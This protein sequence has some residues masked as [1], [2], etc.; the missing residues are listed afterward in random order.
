MKCRPDLEHRHGLDGVGIGQAVFGAERVQGLEEV[1]GLR[2]WTC[3]AT[4]TGVMKD[5]DQVPH[6]D[7]ID[8]FPVSTIGTL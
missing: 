2:C 4:S 1:S 3:S 8:R 5:P 7:G 6:G